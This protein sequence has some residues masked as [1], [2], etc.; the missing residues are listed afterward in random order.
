VEPNFFCYSLPLF[1]TLFILPCPS[2]NVYLFK[3][4]KNLTEK[5]TVFT[6]NGMPKVLVKTVA[7]RTVGSH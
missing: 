5:S 7:K 2:V 3:C 6:S 4:R 1:H